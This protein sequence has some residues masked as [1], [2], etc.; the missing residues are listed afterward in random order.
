MAVT[1]AGWTP[2]AAARGA[3][4]VRSCSIAFPCIA[5]HDRRRWSAQRSSSPPT[6]RATSQAARSLLMADTWQSDL[7][8]PVRI[9]EH[10]SR[11]GCGLALGFLRADG[12][13]VA[14]QRELAGGF[15]P[16]SGRGGQVPQRVGRGGGP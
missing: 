8:P 6:R 13:D 7:A 12:H 4:I 10:H 1:K 3:L 5:P 11:G 16:V 15:D 2:T 9:S 14:E